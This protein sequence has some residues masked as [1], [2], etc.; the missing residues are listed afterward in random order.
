MTNTDP[1][2]QEYIFE[3]GGALTFFQLIEHFLKL[4]IDYSFK[5][6]AVHLMGKMPFRFTGDDF[7][8]APL[9]RLLAS[10]RK[11]S[12]NGELIA[13]LEKLKEK[14][15]F[16]AHKSFV[17]YFE[18]PDIDEE[19]YQKNLNSAKS[20]KEEAMKGFFLLFAEVSKLNERINNL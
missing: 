17:Q 9:E 7:K 1:R 11:L 15:N 20:I 12:D 8:N 18:E 6:A 4:Y 5:L 16:F 19:H 2:F 14:R 10:F 13:V 3:A